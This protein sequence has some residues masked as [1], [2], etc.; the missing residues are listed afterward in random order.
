LEIFKIAA[1]GDETRK[2]MA[3]NT[4]TEIARIIGIPG[5]PR[6]KKGNIIGK[7]LEPHVLGLLTHVNDVISA[8]T[9]GRPATLEHRLY[10]QAVEE[11]IRVCKVHARIA[12]PQVRCVEVGSDYGVVPF[13]PFLL[14][15][16]ISMPV[17]NRSSP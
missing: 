17:G 2:Q 14:D 9:F 16:D 10:L 3:R 15:A 4:L 11:M 1:E 6:P 5:E 13:V 7:F 12:R 8:V